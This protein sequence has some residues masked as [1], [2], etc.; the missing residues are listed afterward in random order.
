MLVVSGILGFGSQNTARGIR[1]PLRVKPR[2]SSDKDCNPVP[3]IENPRLCWIPLD[4][5][6]CNHKE[7]SV[8]FFV[9]LSTSK[10]YESWRLKK[11]QVHV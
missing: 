9:F 1:V 7:T 8:F 3:E 5:A 10:V 11:R 6:I 2:S 4:G